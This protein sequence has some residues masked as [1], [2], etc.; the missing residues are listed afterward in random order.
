MN[1]EEDFVQSSPYHLVRNT[2]GLDSAGFES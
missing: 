2:L 1:R